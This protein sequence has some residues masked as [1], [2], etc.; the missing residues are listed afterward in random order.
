M[1]LQLDAENY[2][3]EG[4]L[5]KVK[6]ERGYNYSDVIEVSPETLPNYETKVS[7]NNIIYICN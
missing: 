4:I 1:C 3:S 6:K 2:E 7:F 5:E